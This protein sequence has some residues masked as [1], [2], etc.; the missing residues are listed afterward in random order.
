VNN[1]ARDVNDYT[2][3]YASGEVTFSSRRLLLTHHELQ[4]ILNILI[5]QFVRNLVAGTIS[6]KYSAEIKI[7]RV[8]Y[9]GSR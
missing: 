9:A 7:E 2:I 8:V 6:S 5:Q 1:D 4:S 3:D